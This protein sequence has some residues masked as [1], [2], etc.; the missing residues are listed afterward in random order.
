M[1]GWGSQSMKNRAHCLSISPIV[2]VSEVISYGKMKV[3]SGRSYRPRQ[4]NNEDDIISG[5]IQ[6]TI[7]RNKCTCLTHRPHHKTSVFPQG[8]GEGQ[9]ARCGDRQSREWALY[10]SHVHNSPRELSRW[11][12]Y[13]IHTT[14]RHLYLSLF[15]ST[16]EID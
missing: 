8:V 7:R 6:N 12:Q 15:S 1:M 14:T 16:E 4:S 5:D 10:L 13:T 9:W 2:R 3:E 11:G